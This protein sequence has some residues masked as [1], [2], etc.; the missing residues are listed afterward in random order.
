M[1]RVTV[2]WPSMDG[3]IVYELDTPWVEI[4]PMMGSINYEKNSDVVDIPVESMYDA[5][6]VVE[7][8]GA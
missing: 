3:Q 2:E 4:D 8:M 1:Y 7:K 6:I 5:R